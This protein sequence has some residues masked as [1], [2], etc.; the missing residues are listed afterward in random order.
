MST[1]CPRP[2]LHARGAHAVVMPSA[3][4]TTTRLNRSAATRVAL[5]CA[6]TLAG[7]AAAQSY[8][9]RP[10]RV[11]VPFPAGGSTDIV[12]RVVSQKLADEIGRAHV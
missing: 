8:P 9:T 1:H 4:R 5:L 11:I 7:P 3:G 2:A 6:A 10:V 12:S